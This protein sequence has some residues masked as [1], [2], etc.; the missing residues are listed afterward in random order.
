MR[1]AAQKIPDR[2]ARSL[3][4]GLRLITRTEGDFLLVE[5]A[6]CPKGH[7][8]IVDSVRIHDQASVKL[9]IVASEASGFVFVDAFWGSHSKLFSFI[10]V[11]PTRRPLL[12]DARCPY[13]DVSLNERHACTEKGCGSES[14][15]RLLL[16]GGRNTIHVCARL[17]CPGH[18]LDIVDMPRGVVRSVSGINYFGA[19][20]DRMFG[21]I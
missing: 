13:C 7:N 21:D 10:P 16:P 11:L 6:F 9:K 19:G 17:G 12:V 2:F 3:P 5:A 15:I 18:L 8:L 20:S 1:L 4:R 14:S